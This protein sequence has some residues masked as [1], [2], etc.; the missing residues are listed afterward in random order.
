MKQ[1]TQRLTFLLQKTSIPVDVEYLFDLIWFWKSMPLKK[2]K[3]NPIL[4]Y[5]FIGCT[6]FIYWKLWRMR[7]IFRLHL[8]YGQ[9]SKQKRIVS[10]QFQ[11][12]HQLHRR[13]VWALPSRRERLEPK[14]HRGQQSPLLLLLHLPSG[15]RVRALHSFSLMLTSF[16]S[17]SPVMWQFLVLSQK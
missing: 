6:R 3:R 12:N 4:V 10:C 1:M 14:A 5:Y 11:H 17:P 16:I 15:T 7:V 8:S 13:P 9:C 2:E